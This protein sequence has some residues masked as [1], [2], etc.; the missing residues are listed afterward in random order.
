MIASIASALQCAAVETGCDFE[1]IAR[2]DRHAD[3]GD[4][5]DQNTP[6]AFVRVRH[7]MGNKQPIGGVENDI[8]GQNIKRVADPPRRP[9]LDLSMVSFIGR[10][11]ASIRS[12]QS[13]T[14]ALN[15][16]TILSR[17][18]ASNRRLCDAAPASGAAAPSMVIQAKRQPGQRQCCLHVVCSCML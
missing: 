14:P 9:T 10:A 3:L 2:Q 5:A 18:K 17:P 6:G 1:F 11:D 7:P 15:N 8:D 13:S 16:S 4:Q 12:R